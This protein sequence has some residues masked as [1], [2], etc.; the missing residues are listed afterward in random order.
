MSNEMLIQLALSIVLG[1]CVF[2]AIWGAFRFPV[3][4]EVP[5]HLRIA[6]AVGAGK[7]Q[8]T[9][10]QPL[11]V[12]FMSMALAVASRLNLPGLRS[13]I[14]RDLGASG[15]MNS[16]SEDEYL[17]LC[18]ACSVGL[19]MISTL[20]FFM[21]YSTF[22][23]LILV[24]TAAIGFYLPINALHGEAQRRIMRISKQLPYSLDLISMM[25]GAG[26]TFNEAI[27]TLIRD[28]PEEDFNQE[29]RLVRA[30]IEFGTSRA[31]ALKNLGERIPLD[32]L[33]SVVGAVNQA[34]S[35]G[36]PLSQILASQAGMLRMY[37][38]VRA[39]KLSASASL[40][41]LIPSML[42]LFAVM[43]IVF[44]PVILKMQTSNPFQ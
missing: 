15:N 5:A 13:S 19:A 38:S 3:S 20:V 23:P 29:L 21:V 8:T 11:L 1:S 32:S 28:D 39:E 27:E 31:I 4:Q 44:G 35:L 36:T 42:I 22:S 26:A 2:G 40:R 16:Y 37:R 30:E 14:S 41:I 6:R 12:P 18:I 34:E 33:R 17:A 10:E 7:R 24:I 25:L 43:L 9:F